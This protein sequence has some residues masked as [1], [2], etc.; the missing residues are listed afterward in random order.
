MPVIGAEVVAKN[1]KAFGDGF[2]KHVNKSMVHVSKILDAEVTMN[3][4]LADEH[5]PQELRRL[6]HPY[7]IGGPG[8]HHPT[9]WKV[10]MQS[11]Q[12]F[13]SKKNGIE[14]ADISGGNLRTRAWAGVDE[15]LAPYALCLIFGTSKMIPRD[16]LTP[17]L[18][19]AK[20][21]A[22][23]Y[24]KRNLRDFVFNFRTLEK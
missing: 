10:H 8:L 2:I 23:E 16:F 5:T 13:M 19:E 6:G 9:P 24:L 12:L 3:I 18:N 7:R 11:G 21:P 15:N 17:A 4:N 20:Q 22:L 14:E 1:L